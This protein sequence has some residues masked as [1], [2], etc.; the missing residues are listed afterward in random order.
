MK[1]GVLLLGM[2]MPEDSS[3]NAV[4]AYAETVFG[5]PLYQEGLGLVQGQMFRKAIVPAKAREWIRYFEGPGKP[6]LEAYSMA[7]ES[8]RG[9]LEREL[10]GTAGKKFVVEAG[11]LCGGPGVAEA[12]G[13]LKAAGCEV[14]ISLPLCPFYFKPF[15]DQALSAARAA[16]AQHKDKAWNPRL[17]EIKSFC[18]NPGYA[19]ALA[20][21]ICDDWEPRN[22]SRLLILMPSQPRAL[23]ESDSTYEEQIAELKNQLQ[24][25]TKIGREQIHVAYLCEFDN[26]K[27]LGPFAEKTLLGWA[28]GAVRD[29]RAVCPASCLPDALGAYDAGLRLGDYFKK[30]VM[31]KPPTYR[32]VPSFDDSD[33]FAKVLGATVRKNA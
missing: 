29:V 23:S 30:N 5:S 7:A 1:Y 22:V 33:D 27:W 14:V 28:G 20:E 26:A 25:H 16:L 2:G 13:K 32:F 17:K 6:S 11:M 12:V 24:K 4:R 10:S 3:A 15:V 19:K 9:K 8:L 21:R 18:K 31:G